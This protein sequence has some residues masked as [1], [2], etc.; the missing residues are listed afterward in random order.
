MLRTKQCLCFDRNFC[1]R[2]TRRELR[3]EKERANKALLKWSWGYSRF[4]SSPL[5]N[6]HVKETRHRRSMLACCTTYI[7]EWQDNTK[8]SY[9]RYWTSR[10]WLPALIS[11]IVSDFQSMDHLRSWTHLD[12]NSNWVSNGLKGR[13]YDPISHGSMAE[14]SA[15]IL[16][17]LW[18]YCTTKVIPIELV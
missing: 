18:H 5:P 9:R 10:Y 16:K 6:L 12:F 2:I 4:L 15:K 17:I 3:E 1:Q 8:K 14:N 13:V 11:D 7:L